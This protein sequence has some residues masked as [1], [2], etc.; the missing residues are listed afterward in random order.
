MVN[1]IAGEEVVPELVQG[2]FTAGNIVAELGKIIP[3]GEPRSR[4]L[5]GLAGVKEKLRRGSAAAPH[6]SEL[7]A[8][9][10]LNLLQ[11]ATRRTVT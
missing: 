5:G 4:M 6:A 7:A 1:L 8:E 3:D 2:K 9:T 10:I 11:K